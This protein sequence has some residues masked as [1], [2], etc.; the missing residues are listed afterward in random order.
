MHAQLR[1]AIYSPAAQRSAVRSRADPYGALPCPSLRCCVVLRCVLSFE[2]RAEPDIIR[3]VLMCYF[4]SSIFFFFYMYVVYLIFHGP[5]FFPPRKLPPYC[6]S[7]R[8]TPVTKAHSTAE[9]NRATCSEQAALGIIKSLFAPNHG[10]PSFCP[11]YMFFVAFFL[12]LRECSGRRDAAE[13]SP[14]NYYNIRTTAPGRE[15]LLT[16][17]L[18]I[19]FKDVSREFDEF[20]V[21]TH[22]CKLRYVLDHKYQQS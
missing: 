9:H 8:N 21:N 4:S 10:P 15:N 7:K 11:L 16:H 20:Q 6:R 13:R 17:F 14:C 22:L 2:H 5:L 12:A 18:K 19:I 1:S 3:V